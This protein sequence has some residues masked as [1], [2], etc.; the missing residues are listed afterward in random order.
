MRVRPALKGLASFAAAVTNI[1]QASE[2]MDDICE[3]KEHF[4]GPTWA[5]CAAWLVL[6]LLAG[7]EMEKVRRRYQEVVG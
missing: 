7:Q 6:V 3:G 4:T 2:L 5:K 1:T